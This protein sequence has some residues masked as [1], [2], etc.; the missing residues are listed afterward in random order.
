MILFFLQGL[1]PPWAQNSPRLPSMMGGPPNNFQQPPPNN[2]ASP[3]QS[4][5]HQPMFTST[6]A[7]IP[8]WQQGL[9]STPT[10]PVSSS[11]AMGKFF[12]HLV[13]KMH[14]QVLAFLRNFYSG[15]SSSP[16]TKENMN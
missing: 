10:Q 11:P 8:P 15:L 13:L 1:T 5:N 14:F 6:P 3:M 2:M 16:C 7:S 4:N 9:N 12:C